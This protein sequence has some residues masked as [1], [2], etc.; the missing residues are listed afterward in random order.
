ME[1]EWFYTKDLRD[2]TT[3]SIH[4]LWQNSGLI[5]SAIEKGHLGSNWKIFNVN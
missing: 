2:M 1:W 5:K 4:H 3:K